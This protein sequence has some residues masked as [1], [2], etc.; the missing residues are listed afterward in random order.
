MRCYGRARQ[1]R[2]NA[3][4][5]RKRINHGLLAA[6]WQ[7]LRAALTRWSIMG[8]CRRRRRRMLGNPDANYQWTPG[9]SF[10]LC[11][12]KARNGER[13]RAPNSAFTQRTPAVLNK[14]EVLQKRE[15]CAV[16]RACGI[17]RVLWS[18]CASDTPWNTETGGEHI[19][20]TADA[21]SFTP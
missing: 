12:K 6:R 14:G 8:C 3:A 11:F 4:D 13:L 20:Q 2:G 18:V 9:T 19:R 17:E 16:K 7:P 15:L 5:S 10:L 21:T 1:R